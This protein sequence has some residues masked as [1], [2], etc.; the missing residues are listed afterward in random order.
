MEAYP[1]DHGP[2]GGWDELGV[3]AP[4]LIALAQLCRE[5]LCGEISDEPLT[6]EAKAILASAAGR[7]VIE[8][9]GVNSAFDSADRLLAVCVE[10]EVDRWR[11]FRCRERPETTIRFLDG[12]RRLCA[13]GLVL[14]QLYREFSLS[15]A[16]FEAARQV[17]RDEVRSLLELAIET[18]VNQ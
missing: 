16:G 9:K 2:A 8:I 5:A 1:K 15:A 3:G 6:P 14:H 10:E 18:E 7:G 12:F 13:A 17:N 4:T 11:I